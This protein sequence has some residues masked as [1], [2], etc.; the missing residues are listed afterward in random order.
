MTNDEIMALAALHIPNVRKLTPELLG[1]A[2]ALLAAA[3]PA[4]S[5]PILREHEFVDGTSYPGYRVRYCKHC[6]Q[7]TNTSDPHCT[8]APAPSYEET[9]LPVPEPQKARQFGRFKKKLASRLK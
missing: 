1:F 8:A 5:A 3:A 4:P 6:C 9:F 2:R 7:T